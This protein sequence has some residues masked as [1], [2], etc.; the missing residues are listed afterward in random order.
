MRMNFILYNFQK[1]EIMQWRGRWTCSTLFAPDVAGVRT[2]NVR[3]ERTEALAQ[4]MCTGD[5]IYPAHCLVAS[6]LLWCIFQG[7][8]S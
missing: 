3:F 1:V 5:S 4:D 7:E 2:G 8:T 6:L